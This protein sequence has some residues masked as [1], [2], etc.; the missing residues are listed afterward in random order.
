[1]GPHASSSSPAPY[2]CS[3]PSGFEGPTCGVNTDDCVEH[4]CANGG[5][6]VDGMGSYTCQCPVQYSGKRGGFECL[7]GGGGRCTC[8]EPLSHGR[9]GWDPASVSAGSFCWAGCLAEHRGQLLSCLSPILPP[10]TACE[11]LV[12]FCSS[13]LNPCQH[14]AQCVGTPDGPRSVLP[15]SKAREGHGPPR[16]VSSAL[17]SLF[18]HL[19]GGFGLG[20]SVPAHQGQGQGGGSFSR[21]DLGLHHDPEW[22]A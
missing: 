15:I 6:C 20:C 11:Q 19:S 3:C 9:K 13:D 18:P 16:H 17:P 1:M 8:P 21:T 7:R 2:R 5:T 4:S 22:G 10:G 12:D 14:E